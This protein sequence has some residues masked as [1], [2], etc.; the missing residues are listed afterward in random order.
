MAFVSNNIITPDPVEQLRCKQHAARIFVDDSFRLA[1]KHKFLFHVAF[2]IN[3]TAIKGKNLNIGLL[4]T[5]KDE[6]NLMVKAV[7]LP[8]YSVTHE[9]LNQYNRKKVVQYQHKYSDSTISFHDDNMGLIN[10]LWQAYYAYYYADPIVASA[11]GAYSK[12]ATKA[13]SYVKNPYGFKGR[14][15]PFF[16]YITLYQ[17]ARHEFVSYKLINPVIT[18]WTGGNIAYSESSTPHSFEMKLAHE[19]VSYD[20]GYVSSGRMEGFGST[21]YDWSPSPLYSAQ[22][23]EISA[24]PSFA[25]TLFGLT[26]TT[27]TTDVS[28]QRTTS[29]NSS[30]AYQALSNSSTASNSGN[31]GLQGVAIPS[32]SSLNSI[33]A[34]QVQL[35]QEVV[36]TPTNRA[37]PEYTTVI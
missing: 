35:A 25:R 15:A 36:N 21:H 31:T 29:S 27:V 6:I 2:N 28:V 7:N 13:A 9:V 12:T 23:P 26:D 5:L 20:T 24:A 17:M 3:W 22:S 33:Q 10:Q 18:S 19:A 1:P 30:A 14:V 11:K 8:G 37:A 32:S 16:N 4:E 34:Q